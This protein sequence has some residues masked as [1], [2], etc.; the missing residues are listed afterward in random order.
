MSLGLEALVSFAV[1]PSFH[2]AVTL[3]WL[4]PVPPPTPIT[5]RADLPQSAQI[6]IVVPEVP[7]AEFSGSTAVSV[8]GE[9]PFGGVPFIVPEPVLRLTDEPFAFSATLAAA[10]TVPAATACASRSGCPA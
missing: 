1:P 10:S 6:C 5:S 7:V 8:T 3:A 4:R 9:P 2:F